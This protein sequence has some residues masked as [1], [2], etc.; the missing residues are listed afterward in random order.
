MDSVLSVSTLDV[1]LFSSIA[2]SIVLYRLLSVPA[3][4]RHIPSVPILPLLYSYFSGEVEEQRVKRLILP[5]AKSMNTHVVLVFC[6]GDWMVQVLE[7]QVSSL[8][9][10]PRSTHW[11]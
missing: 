2:I 4:L 3:H 11:C 5:F 6:L 10:H 1:F 7:P 8:I 9:H